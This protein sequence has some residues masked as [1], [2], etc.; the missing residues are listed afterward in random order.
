MKEKQR[1]AVERRID[2]KKEV[3]KDT[4]R[5]KYE[6]LRGHFNKITKENKVLRKQVKTLEVALRRTIDRL[7]RLIHDESVERVLRRL[8]DIGTDKT[9]NKTEEETTDS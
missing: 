6:S 3:K 7:D 5:E 2:K 1:Q 8:D 4:I 9:D